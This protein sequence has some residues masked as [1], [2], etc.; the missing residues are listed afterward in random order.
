MMYL[1][2]IFSF[3]KIGL[4]GFGGGYAIL[5]LINQE[6]QKF[7]MMAASEFGRL[8]ALSQITPGPIA[9]NSATYVGYQYAGVLGAVTATL[10]LLLPSVILVLLIARFLDRFEKSSLAEDILTGVRPATLGLLLSAGVFLT[11]GSVFRTGI[12][13]R[14]FFENPLA[15]FDWI[16]ILICG[17]TLLLHQKWKISP[18]KLTVLAAVLGSVFIR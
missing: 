12:Y 17:I 10:A 13:T 9:V 5:A 2:L 1:Q 18:I 7:G 14:A 6:T 15:Y 11:E 16:S 3:F 8:V 4:F